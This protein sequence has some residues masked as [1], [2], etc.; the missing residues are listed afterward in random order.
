M[1][2]RFL[3]VFQTVSPSGGGSKRCSNLKIVE[4]RSWFLSKFLLVQRSPDIT[5]MCL[6]MNKAQPASPGW[7]P[8]QR[9]HPK[10]GALDG[11]VQHCGHSPRQRQTQWGWCRKAMK[12]TL[13]EGFL[14]QAQANRKAI[15]TEMGRDQW[16][17]GGPRPGSLAG[18]S[19]NSEWSE[20]V[21]E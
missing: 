7:M 20:L 13:G 14:F 3:I 5:N 16:G 11:W 18:S 19:L 21:R 2:P 8:Y 9:P 6:G 1:E 10:P 4:W 15:R 12:E 17:G